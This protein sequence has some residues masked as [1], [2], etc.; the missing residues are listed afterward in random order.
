MECLMTKMTV[1]PVFVSVGLALPA[2]ADANP[3]EDLLEC[4]VDVVADGPGV[5]PP[6]S[7][8]YTDC[9]LAGWCSHF[10]LDPKF[11][12]PDPDGERCGDVDNGAPGSGADLWAAGADHAGGYGAMDEY[13]NM[14]GYAGNAARENYADPVSLGRCTSR[15]SD[16]VDPLTDP[17]VAL[18]A[19]AAASRIE[20][21]LECIVDA[22]AYGP[23]VVPETWE[24]TDCYVAG[25]CSHFELDPIEGAADPDGERCSAVANGAPGEGAD[26]WAAG[27]EDA[28]SHQDLFENPKGGLSELQGDARFDPTEWSDSIIFYSC[29]SRASDLSDP[30]AG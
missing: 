17:G 11:G 21:F 22:V 14:I 18:P 13:T 3:F 30:I 8:E 28:S 2:Q 20:N 12:K 6:L 16:H 15:D 7:W 29:T 26:L 10:G 1:L 4:V 5:G 25:W 27:A 9:Y 24:Y 19:Q 23:A